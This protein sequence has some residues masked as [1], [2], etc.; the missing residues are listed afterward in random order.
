VIL[1]RRS[2]DPNTTNDSGIRTAANASSVTNHGRS[3]PH[4]ALAS[5][6]FP[7]EDQ[8]GGGENG[9]SEGGSRMN[10]A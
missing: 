10:I 8:N 1:V 2:A 3:W 4:P 6:P 7:N 9:V 5:A